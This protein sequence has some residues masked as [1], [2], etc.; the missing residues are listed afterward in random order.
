LKLFSTEK[1]KEWLQGEGLRFPQKQIFDPNTKTVRDPAQCQI[2]HIMARL[3]FQDST[4]KISSTGAKDN[5]SFAATFEKTFLPHI[6]A[7][8]HIHQYY[9]S[10]ENIELYDSEGKNVIEKLD[11]KAGV[12]IV[13]PN[14]KEGKQT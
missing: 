10:I 14:G 3:I 8:K 11:S 9:L 5:P 12:L 6:N 13:Q 7:D 2:M 4:R 1:V